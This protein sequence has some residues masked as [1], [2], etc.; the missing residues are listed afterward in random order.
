M[1]HLITIFCF[2]IALT[3]GTSS[4]S[5]NES[6]DH[7]N[8]EAHDGKACCKGKKQTCCSAD[9]SGV[10]ECKAGHACDENCTNC[11]EE[12]KEKCKKKQEKAAG[13]AESSE[14]L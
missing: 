14:E 3:L 13:E 12:C 8:T 10:H 4:C 7:H 11:S 2:A 6:C 5:S 9:S 1:K